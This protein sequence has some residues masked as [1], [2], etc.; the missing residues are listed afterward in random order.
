MRTKSYLLSFVCIV[1]TTLL[2]LLFGDQ[3]PS[4]QSIVTET[5]KQLTN[6]LRTFK[7]NLKVVEEKRLEA[8]E[9]YLSLLGFTQPEPRLY[10]G[11]V[12]TNTSLPVVVTYLLDGQAEHGVSLIRNIAHY[13]PNH[14]VLI[15]NLGLGR[16]QLHL[17]QLNCN[18]SH[19][20]V[21]N[22]DLNAFPS[23]VS[24]D[25][26]HAFRPLIIQDALNR[27]GAILYLACDQR[28]VTSSINQ[29]IEKAVSS[30]GTGVVTWA[31]KHAVTSLTHPRM[32]DYFSSSDDAFFFLPMVDVDRLLVYNTHTVHWKLMLPW[33]QCALI[34]D[35]IIPIGAQSAGCRFN[36]K[37]QYRYSGCH[38][39]DVSA[40]NIVLGL[41]FKFNDMLYTYQDSASYFK[42]VTLA[43][44]TE[45][46]TKLLENGTVDSSTTD[47]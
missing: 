3:R 41:T 44:A 38:S 17:L 35:C 28:L 14:T 33:V 16:Y 21:I 34:R 19:C 15:Y 8:D 9:E 27:A 6:N 30:P 37:P 29:L 32:F 42:K 10:P 1:G 40:F 22:F 7:D 45:E 25:K 2:L 46:V 36:K 12:W 23:F 26:L 39:Y 20:I 13:L 11:V 18:N 43:A 47:S 31:T 4:I 24:D 5:H